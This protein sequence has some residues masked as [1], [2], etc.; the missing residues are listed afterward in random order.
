MQEQIQRLRVLV[1]T[2]TAVGRQPS[3]EIWE[4]MAAFMGYQSE[5]LGQAEAINMIKVSSALSPGRCLACSKSCRG[6]V[7]SRSQLRYSVLLQPSVPSHGILGVE[8]HGRHICVHELVPRFDCC[9]LYDLLSRLYSACVR[10][11]RRAWRW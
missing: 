6:Q 10:L 3:N 7:P 9:R 2:W 1:D 8:C 4:G 11:H 5:T